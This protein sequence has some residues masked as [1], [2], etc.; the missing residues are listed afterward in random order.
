MDK[1]KVVIFITLLVL[2]LAAG[3]T[4]INIADAM[5]SQWD[6]P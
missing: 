2:L 1:L 3:L 6:Q 4:I 5:P